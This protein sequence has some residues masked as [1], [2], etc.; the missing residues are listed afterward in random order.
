[1]DFDGKGV[2]LDGTAD[3][4]PAAKAG[5]QRGDIIKKI[6]G[7][8]IENMDQFMIALNALRVGR[9]IDIEIERDGKTLVIKAVPGVK[10]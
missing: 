6:S 9:E 2:R 4:S 10:E 5:L 8:E 3:N 7:R 1:M